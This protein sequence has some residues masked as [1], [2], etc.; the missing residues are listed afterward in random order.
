MKQQVM[1]TQSSY[2]VLEQYIK[3]KQI[4]KIFLVCGSSSH[5]LAAGEYFS[6]LENTQGIEVCRFSDYQP[7]PLY[8]SVKTGVLTFLESDADCIAAIGGGSA[9]DV[10]KCI[11]A[12]ATMDQESSYLQ[13]TI[14][15]NKIPLIA[16]PTTAGTGSE[17][18]H[19]AVI[20]N[21]GEKLSIAHKSLIP[22]LVILD[23][24]NL[25]TLPLYQRQAT[26]M[27]AFCHAIEAFWSVNATP[28]SDEYAKIAIQLGMQYKDGYL[29]NEEY[30]SQMML[31][32]AYYAGKAINITKTTAAHAMSYKLTSM[33]HI[34]HGHAAAVCLS[35]VWGHLLTHCT[36][37]D[38]ADKL[39]KIA[40]AMG[41]D[42]S[43]QALQFFRKM[44]HEN[45]L[46]LEKDTEA[47]TLELLAA[48]VNIERLN[49][50]PIPLSKEELKEL[51][52]R[53]LS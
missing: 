50:H 49:N 30:G 18:T 13:Q 41:S 31:K 4:R 53:I 3:E 12:F 10:A 2:A 8:E 33:Y 44:I 47:G 52:K 38:N 22:E 28:E 35:E 17:A 14:E 32:A 29:S 15:E 27:D 48:S 39:Q 20:Y 6:F 42:N 23:S 24:N 51:Y 26:M 21:G 34:A 19:F 7:N 5:K 37:M 36:G 46:K 40:D 43:T 25:T 9:M 1:E 45:N 11:K 16:I